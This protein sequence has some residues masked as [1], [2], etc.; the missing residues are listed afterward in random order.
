MNATASTDPLAAPYALATGQVA[1]RLSVVMLDQH[2]Q[3]LLVERFGLP[4]EAADRVAAT[5]NEALAATWR[6]AGYNMPYPTWITCLPDVLLK[7]VVELVVRAEQD[8]FSIGHSMY[9]GRQILTELGLQI[10]RS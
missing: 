3:A 7:C 6:L 5:I 8:E 1:E 2:L 10:R 9:L 4:A